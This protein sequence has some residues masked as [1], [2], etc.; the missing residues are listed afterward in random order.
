MLHYALCCT[1]LQTPTVQ[2]L[3]PVTKAHTSPQYPV[4]QQHQQQEA[5]NASSKS[6]EL[7]DDSTSDV[8]EQIQDVEIDL[9]T[10]AWESLMQMHGMHDVTSRCSRSSSSSSSSDASID[11]CNSSTSA[12]TAAIAALHASN[13]PP[14]AATVTSSTVTPKS[15]TAA[16]PTAGSRR[17][18]E[19]SN[20]E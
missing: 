18:P 6:A 14:P 12:F 7:V 13:R 9:A 5:V 4:Q 17:G 20:S 10:T 2:P 16:A 8:A 3:P 1:V 11:G 15:V 19:H